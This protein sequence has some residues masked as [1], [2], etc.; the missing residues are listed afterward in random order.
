M[1][2]RAQEHRLI[3]LQ[4]AWNQKT[5]QQWVTIEESA[6][7]K[8]KT[9][10]TTG[11]ILGL[12]LGL[13][14]NCLRKQLHKQIKNT[15]T[16]VTRKTFMIGPRKILFP[17]SFLCSYSREVD[18]AR[19]P[20][21][22]RFGSFVLQPVPQSNE[23]VGEDDIAEINEFFAGLDEFNDSELKNTKLKIIARKSTSCSSYHFTIYSDNFF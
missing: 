8:A 5:I 15:F 4:H 10:P 11:K 21:T 1:L 7:T 9:L 13:S 18:R 22:L 14:G 20:P 3:V 12:F 16:G 6:S 19:A 2:W 23:M 17:S